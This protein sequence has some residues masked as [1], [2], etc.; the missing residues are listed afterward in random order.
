MRRCL[1]PMPFTSELITSDEKVAEV[2][3]AI[4]ASGEFAFDLEFVSDGRFIPELALV[5]LAWGD[6][7]APDI[8]LIDCK[9]MAPQPIFDLIADENI[10]TI[11][12]AAKQDLGLLV[13][14]YDVRAKSLW[15]TQI[16][17]AFVGLGEQIGYGK[18]VAAELDLTLDKGAQFTAWLKRP[19]TAAQMRY[20]VNDVLY[21]PR[22]WRSLK[23]QLEERGR[24]G[25]VREESDVMARDCV[26]VPE[27]GEAYKNIKAWKSMQPKALG[28]LRELAGW[29]IRTAVDKNKPLSWLLPDKAM[30]EL[31]R[32]P[33]RDVRD[34]KKVRGVG[35]G[36][37][38]RYGEVIVDHIRAGMA[39]PIKGP[40]R[41]PDRQLSAHGQSWSSVAATVIQSLAATEKIAARFLGTRSDAEDLVLWYET[42]EAQRVDDEVALLHG[43]RR[44]LAGNALLRWLDGAESI[45]ADPD[46]LGGLSLIS[47]KTADNSQS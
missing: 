14:R 17:A 6:V 44:E 45:V 18:L 30:V 22:M 11:A 31:C 25:W 20:A 33:P 46:S 23:A 26:R 4:A 19:L 43:W 2:A 13:A 10:A 24:L 36:T 8:A 28:A 39:K 16:A 41:G 34:I 29:R 27:E 21:L 9:N 42:P 40:K 37:L 1:S 38:R 12:H 3:A 47:A 15:D 5:Q 32:K 35:E 7:E